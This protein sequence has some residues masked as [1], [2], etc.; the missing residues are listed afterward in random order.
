MIAVGAVVAVVLV[1]APLFIVKWGEIR[2]VDYR[3]LGAMGV[4]ASLA[5]TTIA[6]LQDNPWWWPLITAGVAAALY[7]LGLV[8]HQA[9]LFIAAAIVGVLGPLVV[10][11]L[12]NLP[13][14]WGAGPLVSL[15]SIIVVLLLLAAV[16]VGL[17]LLR[18]RRHQ[19]R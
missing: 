12:L 7:V 18:R 11:L 9:L 15:G 13:R 3:V 6:F 14:L 16:A 19:Q 4:I 17:Y 10:E 5:V 2:E 1:M 8:L